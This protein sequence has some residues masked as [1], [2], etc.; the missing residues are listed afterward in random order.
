MFYNGQRIET[1]RLVGECCVVGENTAIDYVHV[2]IAF[3]S[4]NALDKNIC[5]ID[6]S[7]KK[8]EI[9]HSLE[10][11]LISEAPVFKF[12]L[13]TFESYRR[14][15][16]M[17]EAL[18]KVLEV[19][20]KNNVKC[21]VENCVVQTNEKSINFHEKFG[22]IKLDFDHWF[23]D[24]KRFEETA[25]KRKEIIEKAWTGSFILDDLEKT[26]LQHH[27]YINS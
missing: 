9:G 27:L 18:D 6:F 4:R 24:K 1:R 19:I 15:N 16:Y 5:G 21:V 11:Y 17:T 7:F 23:I 8:A 10:K 3:S 22:F 13:E 12:S 25:E 2:H 14:Q 20:F 26:S